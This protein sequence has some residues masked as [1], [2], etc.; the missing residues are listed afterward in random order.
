MDA[1]TRLDVRSFNERLTD[2]TDLIA[3]LGG[4]DRILRE[5]EPPGFGFGLATSAQP[6]KDTAS[7]IGRRARITLRWY[8]QQIR[9]VN[10]RYG[11]PIEIVLYTSGTAAASVTLW[12]AVVRNWSGTRRSLAE[13]ES[14]I[15]RLKLRRR[16]YELVTEALPEEIR[17]VVDVQRLAAVLER[18]ESVEELPAPPPAPALPPS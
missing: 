16:A 10:L 11:S 7:A 8:T 3:V 14:E 2:L 17:D 6:P 4:S 9:I 18:I 1:P 15:A 5:A 12:L 13:D